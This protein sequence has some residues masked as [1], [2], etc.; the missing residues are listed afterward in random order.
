[1]V[2]RTSQ[3]RTIAERGP[4]QLVGERGAFQV[5]VRSATVVALQTV[6]TLV[7]K[8]EDF[9]AF[10]SAHPGVLGIELCHGA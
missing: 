8:T 2:N 5:N 7:M 4:G 1:M 9:A 3:Q 10:V 6:Q